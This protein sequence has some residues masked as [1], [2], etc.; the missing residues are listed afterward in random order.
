MH[1]PDRLG[2]SVRKVQRVRRVPKAI[3]AGRP[4]RKVNRDRRASRGRKASPEN[5]EARRGPQGEQG[6][7]GELS[8]AQLDA[9]ITGTAN[10]PSAI[11]P[12]SGTFSDPPTQAEMQDFAAWSETLRAALVR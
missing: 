1:R 3:Q 2:R 6:L 11:A 9:A 5:R 4:V 7:P 8:Q 12:F 10:N